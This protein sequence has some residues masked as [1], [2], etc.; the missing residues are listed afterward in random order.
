MEISPGMII[1]TQERTS[2]TVMPIVR[3]TEIVA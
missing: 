2:A 1:I 3:Y